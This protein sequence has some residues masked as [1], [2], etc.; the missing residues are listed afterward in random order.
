MNL[1]QKIEAFLK[2]LTKLSRLYGL[3]LSSCSCCDGANLYPEEG[4]EL[5]EYTCSLHREREKSLRSTSGYSYTGEVLG[6]SFIELKD[7]K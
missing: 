4:L 1:E 5:K 7:T 2:D 3:E 6:A